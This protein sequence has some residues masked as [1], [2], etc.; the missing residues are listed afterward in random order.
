MTEAIYEGEFSKWSDVVDEFHGQ[1]YWEEDQ[2]AKV[3]EPT[4]VIYAGYDL[5]GYDGGAFV[6]WKQGRKYYTLQGSH[7]SCYGLE[8]TGWDPE[9]FKNKAAIKA[10]LEK[11]SSIWPLCIDPK[12][13]IDKL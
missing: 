2:K 3:P 9:E 7:C 13:L 6:L 10:Y 5:D 4:R 11:T 12:S 1:K 8:E